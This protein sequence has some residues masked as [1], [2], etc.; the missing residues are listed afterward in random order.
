M[1]NPTLLEYLELSCLLTTGI[2]PSHL[3]V[4]FVQ[5]FEQVCA[6]HKAENESHYHI[7]KIQLVVYYQCYVLIG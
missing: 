7:S 6:C 2:I 5:K 3:R 1:I 4:F